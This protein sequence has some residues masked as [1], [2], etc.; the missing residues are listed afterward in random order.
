[1]KDKFYEDS[2][3]AVYPDARMSEVSGNDPSKTM[4]NSTYYVWIDSQDSP[5]ATSHHSHGFA[6]KFAYEYLKQQGKIN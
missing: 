3:K 5:I 1:M 2:V 4:F 6:W